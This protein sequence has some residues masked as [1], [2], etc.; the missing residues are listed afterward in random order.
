MH[1]WIKPRYL[2]FWIFSQQ[3]TT[4]TQDSGE[5]S[6]CFTEGKFKKRS[7]VTGL[8][9]GEKRWIVKG[10]QNSSERG[11]GEGEM[12]AAPHCYW[13]FDVSEITFHSKYL[14][15]S[16]WLQSPSKLFVSCRHLPYL[17][18]VGNV[19]SIWRYNSHWI[20]LEH[21]QGRCIVLEH[22]NGRRDV[23]WKRSIKWGWVWYEALCWSRRIFIILHISLIRIQ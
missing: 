20:G 10:V 4:T 9:G 5:E 2:N 16:D 23:M 17:E 12:A 8:L 22:Q 7:P 6:G 15:V 18:D 13:P 3:L 11:T 14:T 1:C 19:P 21:Q